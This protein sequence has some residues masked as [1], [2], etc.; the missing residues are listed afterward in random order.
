MLCPAG[1]TRLASNEHY[2]NQAFACGRNALTI[3]FHLE[4]SPSQLEEWHVGHAIELAA[5][6]PHLEAQAAATFGR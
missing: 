2:E 1:A 4:A 6:A 5:A 3:Q